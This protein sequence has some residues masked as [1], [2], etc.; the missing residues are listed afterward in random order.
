MVVSP[1]GLRFRGRVMPCVLGRG[2]VARAKREGDGATPAGMHRIVSVLYRPDRVAPPC[3]W[4]MPLRRADL[5]SDDP[6]DPGYNGL[7][8]APHP[9]SH[10]ALWRADPLYD[11]I[12]VTD[13]NLAPARPGRGSAIFMHRWRRG[14][15]PTAGCVALAPRDLGWIAARLA[16][17]ARLCVP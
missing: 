6:A 11:V 13:W 4:A 1:R 12:L 8:R 5:W 15:Y 7:V 2:G 14:G 16:P 10:E 17:G 3:D 9:F